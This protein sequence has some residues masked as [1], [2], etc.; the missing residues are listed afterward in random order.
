MNTAPTTMEGTAMLPPK[1]VERGYFFIRGEDG[2]DY[3]THSKELHGE[4]ALEQI[5]EG[6]RFRFRPVPGNKKGPKAI[7]VYPVAA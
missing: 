1:G 3:F 4:I 6:D 2:V 7:D 5:R